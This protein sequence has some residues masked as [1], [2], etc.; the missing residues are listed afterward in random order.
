MAKSPAHFEVDFRGKRYK[1]A[2]A[3]LKALA[4][5]M[6]KPMDTMGQTLTIELRKFLKNAMQELANKHSRPYPGG[7]TSTTLSRRSGKGFLAIRDGWK[8]R[9]SNNIESVVGEI[10]L[11]QRVAVHEKGATITPKKAKYLTIP[12][13]AA[14]RSNGT[15][16]KPSARQWRNTFVAESKKGNLLIF[17]KKGNGD[18]VPLYALKKSVKIPPRLGLTKHMYE[19]MPRFVDRAFEAMLDEL[20]K[21]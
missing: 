18:I 19:R 1:S 2:S 10:Y 9:G 20:L 15:P 13:P 5:R 21:H 11:P 12:L 6:D 16:I 17:L 3:G 8:V 7:T 4:Q 14:L